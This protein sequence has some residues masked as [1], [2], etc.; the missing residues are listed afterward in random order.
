MFLQLWKLNSGKCEWC[1]SFVCL[2][3]N[4]SLIITIIE[5]NYFQGQTPR[6]TYF[7]IGIKATNAPRKAK[8]QCNTSVEKC[9]RLHT[10]HEVSHW[11]V[12]RYHLTTHSVLPMVGTSLGI[13]SSLVYIFLCKNN[14]RHL[15]P[16]WYHTVFLF[17]RPLFN[18]QGALLV[19]YANSMF[20]NT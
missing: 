18:H 20:P 11:A 19:T 9:N 17:T 13:R 15:T 10:S 16:V 3:V 1:T 8:V 12:N 5:L 7:P 2:K 14:F 4:S 6:V